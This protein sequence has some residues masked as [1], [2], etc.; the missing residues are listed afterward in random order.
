MLLS[1]IP[2]HA[3]GSAVYRCGSVYTNQPLAKENCVRLP[4][5]SAVVIDGPSQ[6]TR[7]V[8]N[9]GSTPQPSR[10][11]SSA[12]APVSQGPPE[13]TVLASV[14]AQRDAQ[15]KAVLQAEWSRTQEKLQQVQAEYRQ[16]NPARL[17]GESTGEWQARSTQMRQ[18]LI[19]LQADLASLKREMERR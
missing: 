3:E 8:R 10:K 15:A 13:A 6:S 4:G 1:T 11:T 9:S 17:P 18:S 19:R 7:S 2:V 5:A 16:G 12:A 14:Q